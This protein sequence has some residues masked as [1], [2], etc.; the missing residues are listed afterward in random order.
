MISYPK[1]FFCPYDTA[2][3]SA[4]EFE[5]R[6][7]GESLIS[8]LR[9]FNSHAP[10]PVRKIFLSE[11]LFPCM[12]NIEIGNLISFMDDNDAGTGSIRQFLLNEIIENDYGR[13]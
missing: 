9:I 5:E 4:S 13:S 3:E 8:L 6:I 10:E 12:M 7:K 11:I 1:N 2:P